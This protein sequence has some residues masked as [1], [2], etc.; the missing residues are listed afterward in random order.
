MVNLHA[1]LPFNLHNRV[2][3]G[4]LDGSSSRSDTARHPSPQPSVDAES[5]QSVSSISM[6]NDDI[7]EELPRRPGIAVR[8]VRRPSGSGSFA[9]RGRTLRRGQG[10]GATIVGVDGVRTDEHGGGN[11]YPKENGDSARTSPSE[12][13]GENEEVRCQDLTAISANADNHPIF[14]WLSIRR[15]H[16]TRFSDRASQS[17]MWDLCRAVGEID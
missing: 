3:H 17:R 1:P 13:A 2:L 14:V 12:L 8:L 10:V 5:D 6:P 9:R 11:A 4:H 16:L 15:A 7:G